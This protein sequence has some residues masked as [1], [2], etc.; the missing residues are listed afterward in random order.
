M[1]KSHVLMFG[2]FWLAITSISFLWNRSR[3]IDMN[4]QIVLNKS[5]SFFDHI[6]TTRSWN[7]SH[8]GVYVPVTALTQ[9]NPYLMDP[10]RDITAI[11]G[12][13]Y[14]KINPA[15]MTRQISEINSDKLDVSFHI[16]SEKPLR[17]ANKAD[18]WET[19]SL[20]SFKTDSDYVL[21]LV[22]LNDKNVYRFMS[23][24]ITEQS[25]LKCHAIQG[26]KVGDIRGGISVSFP[27]DIYTNTVKARIKN[28]FYLHLSF[29]ILGLIGF[30]LYFRM[31]NKYVIVIKNKNKILN[32]LIAQ[33]DKFF[34]ILSH[35]LKS[36]FN[37]LIG[38][39]QLLVEHFDNINENDK[40]KYLEMLLD[41]TNNVYKLLENLLEWSRLQ[42]GLIVYSPIYLII[43]NAVTGILNVYRANF[44]AKGI[45]IISSI[46]QNMEVFADESM[47]HSILRNLISNSIK[48]TPKDGIIEV[49]GSKEG[50]FYSISVKDSGIGIPQNMIDKLL[51]VGE[52]TSRLGTEGEPS[53]GLGLLLTKEYVD[54]CHGEIFVSSIE[55]QGATIRFT[56]PIK[57]KENEEK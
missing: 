3:I 7:S 35:D 12:K 32:E 55:N 37:G 5:S 19:K 51:T 16:T 10:L 15:Y 11:N 33:K 40:K 18:T 23:P 45:K 25:C 49:T 17:P 56:L 29:F 2:I 54:K 48:F 13:L 6:V 14:T 22:K 28:M 41:S 31:S 1:K 20:K 36:P 42:R 47:L 50:D 27:A 8:G 9:P 26:Y 43:N 4:E 21:E 44:E 30:Y 38:L 24:L 53:T 46:D 52:N 57:E 39:L 34:S